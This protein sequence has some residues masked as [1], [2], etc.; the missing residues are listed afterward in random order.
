MKRL[1][2]MPV[3]AMLLLLCSCTSSVNLTTWKNPA[4]NK[5]VTKVVVMPLFEKVEFMKPFESSMVTYFKERG[6][7]SAGSLEFL[8]PAQ[9]YP[10]DVIKHRCDSI[11]ADAILVFVYEGTDKKEDYIPP[12]TYYSG[13]YGGYWGGG[14]WGGYYGGYAGS[15]TTSGGYW[16]TTNIVN[17]TGKLY[18]K[19]SQDPQWTAEISV[20]DPEYVDQ[21]AYSLAKQI[22]A[23]WQKQNLISKTK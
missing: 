15:Y 8:D 1:L 13:G 12:T 10:L 17:L 7:K 21:A 23:D 14:Y 11:G 9:K 2:L 18:V 4:N 5:Q 19:G 3:A 6:L 16:T 20:T 22:F